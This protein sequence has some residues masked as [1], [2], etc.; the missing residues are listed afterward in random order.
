MATAPLP[1]MFG[2]P[3]FQPDH[4]VLL[5]LQFGGVFDGDDAFVCGNEGG[6]NVEQGG[7]A[8]ARAAGDDDVQPGLD[9]GVKH[10]RPSPERSEPKPIR[11]RP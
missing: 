7:L 3:A 1:S 6:Q 2:G 10:A 4:V 9:A 8:G 11:S 5:Q